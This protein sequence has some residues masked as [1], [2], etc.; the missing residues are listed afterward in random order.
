LVEPYRDPTILV[1]DDELDARTIFG[2]YLEAM[3]C[4]V[5][6]AADAPPPSERRP[7]TCPM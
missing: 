5:Y 3:G 7:P 4:L 6:T 1:V 2:L